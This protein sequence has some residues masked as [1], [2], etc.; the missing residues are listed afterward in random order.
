MSPARVI[1]GEVRYAALFALL[2]F[3]P[4]RTLNW[5]AAWVLLGVMFVT[6]TAGALSVLRVNRDLLIERAKPPIHE[7]QPLADK[8]LL[9]GVMAAFAGLVAFIPFDRFHLRLLGEP[10][11]P[12]RLAG[13]IA[14]AAGWILVSVALR[15][16]AFATTVVRAQADRDQTVIDHGVYAVVRHPMYTGLLPVM[17]GMCLWLG[18]VAACFAAC[19]PIALLVVRI[20]LEERVLRLALP[21]YK[22]YASRV[23]AR[24]IPYVW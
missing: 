21:D 1:F 3:A 17:I 13:L 14:F 5:S 23:R 4:A 24:L 11:F 20:V 16:N 7:G 10:P 22:E 6:R 12:V 19:V 9:P 2:L 15:T 8:F 18:S